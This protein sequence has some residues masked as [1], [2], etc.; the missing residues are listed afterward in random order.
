[1]PDPENNQVFEVTEEGF[2]LVVQ[3][4]G[5]R[6]PTLEQVMRSCWDINPVDRSSF[7]ILVRNHFSVRP[8]R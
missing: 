5:G 7:E 6:G 3:V 8:G 1:M 4:G 2:G